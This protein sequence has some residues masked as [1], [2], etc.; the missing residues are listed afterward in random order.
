MRRLFW[1]GVGVAVTVVVLRQVSKV[2]DRVGEVANAVSPAGIASSITSL[3]DSVKS[4]G[5]Q[6]RESMA[7]NEDALRAALLPDEETL[8]RARETRAARRSRG[9]FTDLDDNAVLPDDGTDYF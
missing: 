1:I 9:A 6:L 2:N 7:Q 3:A 5:G 8:A 4:L